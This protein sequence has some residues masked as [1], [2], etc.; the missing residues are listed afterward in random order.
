MYRGCFGSPHKIAAKPLE[1]MPMSAIYVS[2]DYIESVQYF[3]VLSCIMYEEL[4][5]AVASGAF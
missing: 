3:A 5:N 1:L 4:N 2:I